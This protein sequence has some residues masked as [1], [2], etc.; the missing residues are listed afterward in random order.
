MSASFGRDC[1]FADDRSRNRPL[2]ITGVISESVRL[3]ATIVEF[4]MTSIA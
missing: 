4:K 2:R 1:R 3:T